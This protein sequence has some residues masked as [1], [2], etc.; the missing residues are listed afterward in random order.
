M[1]DALA[2]LAE[3]RTPTGLV[4]F[5]RLRSILGFDAYDASLERYADEETDA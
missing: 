2:A 5:E 1:E 3:G 4:S